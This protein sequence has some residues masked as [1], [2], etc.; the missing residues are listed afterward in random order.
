MGPGA[1][2]IEP[3]LSFVAN[4]TGL[5][6]SCGAASIGG[7]DVSVGAGA[8]GTVVAG[9]AGLGRTWTNRIQNQSCDDMAI[10]Y[11]Y[12]GGKTC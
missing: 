11:R 2:G 7:R 9:G 3:A 10:F 1:A 12:C 8:M 5:C 6:S 4:M